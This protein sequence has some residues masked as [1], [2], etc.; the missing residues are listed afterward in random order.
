MSSAHLPHLPGRPRSPRA[1]RQSVRLISYRSAA[2]AGGAPAPDAGRGSLRSGPVRTPPGGAPGPPLGVIG[3]SAGVGVGGAG[4]AG[5]R[6]DAL[7]VAAVV[8]AGAL[9]EVLAGFRPLHHLAGRV[10][11]E[12]YEQLARTIPA[13]AP[14]RHFAGRRHPALR[15]PTGSPRVRVR[16][17]QEPG[18][19]VAEVC[20]VVFAEGRAQALAMRLERERG[21]WR[22]AVVETTLDPRRARRDAARRPSV[23]A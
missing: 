22:C 14:V 15:Q 17:V 11:P 10:T 23:A 2:A 13:V 9:A 3:V 20:A 12:V 21:R 6:E 19:G 8:I 1:A 5:D 18:P 7:A 4:G 16:L